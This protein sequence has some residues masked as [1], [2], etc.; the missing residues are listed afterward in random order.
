MPKP[1]ASEL[2]NLICSLKYDISPHFVY[3][4]N[5]CYVWDSDISHSPTH[6]GVGSCGN[7]I[8]LFYKEVNGIDPALRS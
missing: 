1:S 2:T 8:F 3:R 6:K 5:V 7:D 4:A